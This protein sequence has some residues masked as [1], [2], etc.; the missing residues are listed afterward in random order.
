MLF[1]YKESC[2]KAQALGYESVEDV[3]AFL[4]TVYVKDSLKW[5]HCIE[6]LRRELGV[7]TDQ[8]LEELGYNINDY[9]EYRNVPLDEVQ[10]VACRR[11]LQDMFDC[12]SDA[13]VFIDGDSVTYLCDGLY[14]TEDGELIDKKG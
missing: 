5:I 12:L 10:V 13:A 9:Y 14:I 3:K 7:T 1:N 8:L 11:E 2:E 4:G 6:A